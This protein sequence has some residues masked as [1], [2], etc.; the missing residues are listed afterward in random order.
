[1]KH[2]V[3]LPVRALMERALRSGDLRREF[4]PPDGAIP[5]GVFGEG[6]DLA[7]KRLSG[8]PL[9]G[10]CPG[11]LFPLKGPADLVHFSRLGQNVHRGK[12]QGLGAVGRHKPGR[13]RYRGLVHD[14]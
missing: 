7:G 4:S 2:A 5:G 12:S 11:P 14:R 13:I 8:A 10:R 6:I 1:M 3:R 9:P